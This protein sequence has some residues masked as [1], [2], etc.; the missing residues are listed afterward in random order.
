VLGSPAE[1]HELRPL[2]VGELEHARPAVPKRVRKPLQLGGK[3]GPVQRPEIPGGLDDLVVPERSS[4]TVTATGEVEHEG[5]GVKLRVAF[6]ARLVAEPRD[7]EVPRV[8]D[9][10]L[11]AHLLAGLRALL[12]RGDGALDGDV[13]RPGDGWIAADERM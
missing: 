13:V 3:S 12:G 1:G 10:A 4:L 11:A 7:D 8:L 6:P 5:V 9:V 2:D